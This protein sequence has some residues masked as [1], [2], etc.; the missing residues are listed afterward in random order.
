[1]PLVGGVVFSASF[2]CCLMCSGAFSGYFAQQSSGLCVAPCFLQCRHVYPEFPDPC[3]DIA[4]TT[5]PVDGTS[6][7]GS[8][9]GACRLCTLRPRSR[10][11]VAAVWAWSI[12]QEALS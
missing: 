1:M 6:G 12:L 10:V 7:G 9:N 8:C 11:T 3:L 4:F 5:T 2:I